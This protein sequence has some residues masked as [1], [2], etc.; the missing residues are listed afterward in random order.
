MANC[1]TWDFTQSC[2]KCSLE[3]VLSWLKSNTKKFSFQ[4]EKGSETGY[5]HFQGRFSLKAK[6][7]RSELDN[8]FD[9]NFHPMGKGAL[10]PTSTENRTNMFYV[11]KAETRIAGPWSDTDQ[12]CYVQKRLRDCK[13]RV[14]QKELL[15]GL[16]D[17]DDR[18]INVLLD[19]EG[20]K[21]KGFVSAYA[22]SHGL[23][24]KVPCIND[25]QQLLGLMCDK[26]FYSNT[27][28]IGAVFIDMPRSMPKTK[29][30][31]IYSAIEQIKDGYLY[32]VRYKF[33]IV[34]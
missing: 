1:C 28:D 29:L 20:G 6:H 25:S 24:F 12:D 14:W 15:D 5:E 4:Q 21:G 13:M 2:A 9:G 31:G 7:R 18:T 16:S 17:R 30:T 3:D 26:C 19:T 23:G 33:R 11:T 8:M 34:L 32:D 10:T 22:H 27:H